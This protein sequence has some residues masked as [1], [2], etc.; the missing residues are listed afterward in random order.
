M[1]TIE[2][3]IKV[4]LSIFNIII[5][6]KGSCNLIFER[7]YS[8]AKYLIRNNSVS[9]CAGAARATPTRASFAL[10]WRLAE[11][12]KKTRTS[13]YIYVRVFLQISASLHDNAKLA[14][15]GVARAAPAH[16]LTELFLIKYFA[17][18]YVRS[19]I[20]LHDPFLRIIIWTT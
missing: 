14:R 15:V 13:Y 11:I 6:K 19:N 5:R 12:C 10:S 4:K 2:Y 16:G 7:T 17:L 18:L 20:T 3:N 8:N 9:P 1:Y